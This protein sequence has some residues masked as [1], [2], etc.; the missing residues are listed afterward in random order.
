MLIANALPSLRERV[1]AR[2]PEAIVVVAPAIHFLSATL[3][4]CSGHELENRAGVA[5]FAFICCC[6][7]SGKFWAIVAAGVNNNSKPNA[8]LRLMM[9]PSG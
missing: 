4:C 1:L 7:V 5:A 2:M 8:K 9:F 3:A 6:G